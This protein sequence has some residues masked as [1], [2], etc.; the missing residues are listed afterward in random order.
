MGS[1]GERWVTECAELGRLPTSGVLGLEG[2]GFPGRGA[3]C[4]KAGG[5]G[6]ARVLREAE[7]GDRAESGS[8]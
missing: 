4:A 6:G 7:P 8:R 2:R 3:D 5:P 1:R